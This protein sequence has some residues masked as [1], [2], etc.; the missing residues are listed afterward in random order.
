MIDM[1]DMID[2][3]DR[4]I[5]RKTE[6]E[7]DSSQGYRQTDRQAN[8]WTKAKKDGERGRER[9]RE[10]KDERERERDQ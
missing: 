10:G 5:Y 2:M 1:K 3:V 9:E 7:I 8:T 4:W 6:T